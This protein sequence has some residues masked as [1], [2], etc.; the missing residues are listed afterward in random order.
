MPLNYRETLGEGK[1]EKEEPKKSRRNFIYEIGVPVVSIGSSLAAAEFFHVEMPY[2]VR[3]QEWEKKGAVVDKFL[4]SI[5]YELPC[6]ELSRVR[7][8]GTTKVILS[9]EFPVH[10]YH[11]KERRGD[12]L[13]ACNEF[14]NQFQKEFKEAT[15]ID[16]QKII[17]QRDNY[18]DPLTEQCSFL[19]NESRQE[20]ALLREGKIRRVWHMDKDDD[21]TFQE[22]LQL[23]E[24]T[25]DSVQCP[26][27]CSDAFEKY[28]VVIAGVSTKTSETDSF[29]SRIEQENNER[30]SLL[31]DVPSA[32]QFTVVTVSPNRKLFYKYANSH[33][34][35]LAADGFPH[36]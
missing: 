36:P 17:V 21:R 3:K 13:Y 2:M 29:S 19:V 23:L 4:K 6:A 22:Y 15:G 11:Y 33:T 14:L 26:P 28:V 9:I 34:P 20:S 7:F 25:E 31:R 27:K 32:T 24:C 10:E 12:Y 16:I 8:E 35:E 30:A 1:P 18:I 5:P